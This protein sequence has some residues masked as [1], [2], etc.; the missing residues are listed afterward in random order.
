VI[1][2]AD[3]ISPSQFVLLETEKIA[4]LVTEHGGPTSHAAIFAR[5]LEI[6]AVTGVPEVS[7]RLEPDEELIVDGL[8]GV[9]VVRPTRAQRAEYAAVADRYRATRDRLD[10]LRGL[11][12]E[13]RDGRKIRLSPTSAA[14]RR[15]RR[16]ALR[17]EGIGCCA[18]RSS[19]SARGLP[20]EEEQYRATCAWRADRARSV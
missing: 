12:S 2:V 1:V 10:E 17:A 8:E 5:S 3:R 20:D 4:G 18:R 14:L 16:Q 9:V 13:T 6:P 7:T 19:R 11:P 15:R